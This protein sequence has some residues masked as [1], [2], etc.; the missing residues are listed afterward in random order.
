MRTKSESDFQALMDEE[1]DVEEMRDKLI[2]RYGKGK[3]F[4]LKSVPKLDHK[5]KIALVAIALVDFTSFCAMAILAPF[6]PSEASLKGVPTSVSG[7][8]FSV[9]A[10]VVFLASPLMGVVV[11]HVGPKFMLIVGVVLGGCCNILFG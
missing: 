2:R 3:G 4:Q 11:T 9:Y 10:L 6:Y 1:M 8:V 7:F 5:Q